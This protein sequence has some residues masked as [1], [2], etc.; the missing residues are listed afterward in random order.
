MTATATAH[1]DRDRARAD[2]AP[3]GA[4]GALASP[5][6]PSWLHRRR[7][8]RSRVGGLCDRR[9]RRSPRTT[10][11]LPSSRRTC[12]RAAHPFGT[13]NLGRDVLS[14][15]M[16]GARDVLIVAPVAALMSVA[17]GTMLG[18]IAAYLRGVPRRG[19]QPGH[20]GDPVDPA[21]DVRSARA[22][23]ARYRRRPCSSSLWRCS[24]RRSCSARC[25]PR[26]SPKRQLDYVTSARLRGEGS[27]VHHDEGDPPEHQWPDHRRAHRARRLRHLHHRHA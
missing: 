25:G 7:V 9:R 12:G 24:S 11:S 20:G 14:R 19:R 5:A 18:L 17:A 8:H 21:R 15:V 3:S 22:D 23:D 27:A 2:G 6:P 1:D 16:V 26:C 10:R 13:D 4:Q